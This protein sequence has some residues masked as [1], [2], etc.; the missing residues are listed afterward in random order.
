[1]YPYAN[2]L[3]SNR[4]AKAIEDELLDGIEA[5]PAPPPS[6][7]GDIFSKVQLSQDTAKLRETSYSEATQRFQ[8]SDS[9]MST[10]MENLDA[11]REEAE[12]EPKPQFSFMASGRP[13]PK[14]PEFTFKFETSEHP[15]LIESLPEGIK[16]VE[17]DSWLSASREKWTYQVDVKEEEEAE[18]ERLLASDPRAGMTPEELEQERLEAIERR[19]DINRL[20]E[21]AKSMKYNVKYTD[22]AVWKGEYER[23]GMDESLEISVHKRIFIPNSITV[24]NLANSL[25]VTLGRLTGV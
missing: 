13:L 17:S 12:T 25:K 9:T 23:P 4:S 14:P 24:A 11:Q 15:D 1:L 3:N 6:A 16:R 7:I 20:V 5:K 8:V 18:A 22:M 19:R 10:L 21:K 2:V